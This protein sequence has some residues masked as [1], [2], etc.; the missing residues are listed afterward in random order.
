MNSQE[1]M[2]AVRQGLT[3]V[4]SMLTILVPSLAVSQQYSL[5]TTGIVTAVPALCT[6]AS[7]AWSIYAHLNMKKVPENAVAVILPPSVPSPPVGATIDLAPLSGLAKVV[8]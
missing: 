6:L 1:T 2:N 8:G 3:A 7:I 5:I 4:F